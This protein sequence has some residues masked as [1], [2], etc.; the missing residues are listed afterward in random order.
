M[1]APGGRQM[2]EFLAVGDLVVRKS[3]GADVVFKVVSLNESIALLRGTYFRLM[4][5]APLSDLIK[6]NSDY[7]EKGQEL[8]EMAGRKI[9]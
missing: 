1:N 4:A 8:C 9:S 3:H 5:D 2:A 6:V 7:E